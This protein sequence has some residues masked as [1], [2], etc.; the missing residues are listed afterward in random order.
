M[1]HV[2]DLL[3]KYTCYVVIDLSIIVVLV[4]FYFVYVFNL[5]ICIYMHVCIRV[6]NAVHVWL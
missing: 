4:I 5:C 3:N 2:G 6:Y 1:N